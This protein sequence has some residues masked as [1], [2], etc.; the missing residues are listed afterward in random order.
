MSNVNKGK[1]E[2]M[3][4]ISPP[5]VLL[6]EYHRRVQSTFSE[7]FILSRQIQNLRQTRDLLLPRLMS[8]NVNLRSATS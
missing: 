2:A 7:I 5:A 8:G 3:E 6:A 4:I 1:F